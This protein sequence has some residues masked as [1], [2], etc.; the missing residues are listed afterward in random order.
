MV[1]KVIRDRLDAILHWNISL[2]GGFLGAYAILLHAGNFGS[3]QTGNLMEMGAELVSMEWFNVLL[4]LAALVL[5]GLGVASAYLLTN[6]TKINMRKLALWV[7][8]A[9]LALASMLPLEPALV[10]IY[11]IF[12][13]SA[14][15]WGVY[16]GADGFNSATIFMTNNFKQSVL[17]WL[18]YGLTKDKEFKRKAILYTYTVISF[19]LGVVLGAWAVGQFGIYSA[20]VGFLPLAAA[21]TFI[22]V[23]TA[24]LESET[25]EQSRRQRRWKKQRSWRRSRSCK[26]CSLQVFYKMQ[27]RKAAGNRLRREQDAEKCR[28]LRTA[29]VKQWTDCFNAGDIAAVEIF[30]V[31]LL[32]D[33]APQT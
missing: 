9:A 33:I 11:P 19:F 15:Q 22:A 23:G 20:Y 2:V 7:D 27:E 18:Q 3:A 12:F 17:G 31:F 14:F 5:F 28:R 6:F 10:G 29:N 13:A 25:P 1:Q 21:R 24:P 8:A 32:L 30:P 26:V 4:R 16:S